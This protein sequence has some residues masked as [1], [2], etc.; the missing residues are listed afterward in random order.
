[1]VDVIQLTSIGEVQIMP[2]IAIQRLYNQQLEQPMCQTPGEIVAWMGAI[3][4]QEY[5][6]AKWALGLRLPGASDADI[7]QAFTNGE[8][9]RT[10]VMRPTWH[11]VAP[12]DIRWILALTGPRVQALNAYMY[13]QCEL[14]N[15]LLVHGTDVIAKA[16][17]GGHQLTRTELAAVLEQ[18]GIAADGFRLGYIVMYAELEAVICS[19]PR[20]GKQF[21]YALLAER[22]PQAKN[23]DRDEALAELV[24]RFFTSRGPAMVQDFAWWS[25]LTQADTKE[26]L[27]L[28][29]PDLVESVIDG[30]TYWHAASM[31]DVGKPAHTGYLLPAYD[32]YTIAYRQHGEILDPRFETPAREAIFGGVTV[33]NY[34]VLGNWK[35]TISKGKA[36]I[37]SAPF[38]PFTDAENEAFAEAAQRFGEF[39]GMPVVVAEPSN[40]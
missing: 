26:G 39:L 17:A 6:Q 2:S 38:R 29:K 1:M 31:R 28:C 20:R 8:F 16:L 12:A 30:K 35:R 21:T 15:D 7:E 32:E 27:E 19:G 33:I 10:H 14:D 13:R 40:A 25:G 36:I 34:Q 4:G 3:Q 5:A 18:A 11:F 9:L 37:E 23:L 22:A 24:R